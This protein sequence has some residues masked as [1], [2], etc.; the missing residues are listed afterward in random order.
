MKFVVE[1]ERGV[2]GDEIGEGI[3]KGPEE[4]GKIAWRCIVQLGLS[5]TS[6]HNVSQ[7]V[8]HYNASKD[9]SPDIQS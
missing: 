9:E 3:A 4:L 8:G 6:P 7:G 2:V 1:L 5:V